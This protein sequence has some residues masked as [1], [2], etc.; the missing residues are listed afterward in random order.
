MVHKFSSENMIVRKPALDKADLQSAKHIELKNASHADIQFKLLLPDDLV[1]EN[2]GVYPRCVFNERWE[3]GTSGY[4][5]EPDILRAC[6][7]QHTRRDIGGP[8]QIS[9]CLHRFHAARF[10]APRAM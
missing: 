7:Q 1:D 5:F 3:I 2:C 10:R 6:P 4:V 9:I 8:S